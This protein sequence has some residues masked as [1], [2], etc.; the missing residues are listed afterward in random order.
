[1]SQST[2]LALLE[3]KDHL[4]QSEL[5]DMIGLNKRSIEKAIKGLENW[6]RIK[7]TRMYLGKDKGTTFKIVKT[8]I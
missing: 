4:I 2:L 7:R 6:G 3:E 1:M 8:Q 5:K